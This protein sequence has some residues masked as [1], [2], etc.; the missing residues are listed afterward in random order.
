V[1]ALALACACL[2]ARRIGFALPLVIALGATIGAAVLIGFR[3][4]RRQTPGAGRW[5]ENW[6]GVWTLVLYLGLGSAPLLWRELG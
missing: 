6:S 4:L 3:F 2:A 1:L 5:I